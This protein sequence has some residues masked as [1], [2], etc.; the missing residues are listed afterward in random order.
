[1]QDVPDPP[2]DE[3]AREANHI[4]KPLPP[5]LL[6]ALQRLSWNCTVL[7]ETLHAFLAGALYAFDTHLSGD[8]LPGSMVK[9]CWDAAPLLAPDIAAMYV[10]EKAGDRPSLFEHWA[11]GRLSDEMLS[12]MCAK[13]LNEFRLFRYAG[14]DRIS[15]LENAIKAIEM[16]FS[17]VPQYVWV[18][19]SFYDGWDRVELR[20]RRAPFESDDSARTDR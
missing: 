1:M 9:D 15:T 5:I 13:K 19:G 2:E 12:G 14:Q 16:S 6:T 17:F 3:R 11:A 7:P 10:H 18:A 8:P 4:W 20:C